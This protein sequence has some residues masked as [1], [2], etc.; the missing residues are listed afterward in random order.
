[1]KTKDLKK[2]LKKRNINLKRYAELI[3]EEEKLKKKIGTTRKKR[4]NC[5]KSALSKDLML[6]RLPIPINITFP[7]AKANS[8]QSRKKLKKGTPLSPSPLKFTISIL[9]F[10]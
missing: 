5:V 6:L 10:Y 2:E 3:E 9:K 1:M 8:K 4:K 7:T